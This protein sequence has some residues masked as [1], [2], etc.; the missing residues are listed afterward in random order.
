VVDALIS[1]RKSFEFVDALRGSTAGKAFWFNQFHS[2]QP[3][4][5]SEAK[6]IIEVVQFARA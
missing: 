3:V 1:V 6:E 4:P 5:D 2:F